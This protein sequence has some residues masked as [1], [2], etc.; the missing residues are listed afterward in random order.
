M[1][2]LKRIFFHPLY[3]K[4]EFLLKKYKK[5]DPNR[6]ILRFFITLAL[7]SSM[8]TILSITGQSSQ[9]ESS[10]FIHSTFLGG[11]NEDLI[12]DGE[13][14]Y[15]GNI[16]VTGQTLSPDFPVLNAFQDFFAGGDNDFHTIG[17]DAFI[18]K[19]NSEGQLLWSTY[20]GGSD[21]DSGQSIGL[22]T[23]NNIYIVGV[24]NSIDFPVTNGSTRSSFIGGDYD[25]FI[26]KIA[27]NGTMLYSSYFGT[28]GYDYTEDSEM[29]TSGNLVIVGTTSGTNLPI[30]SDAYQS[31][32][33]G[34]SDGFIA[35]IANDCS[36]IL[37][38]TYFGGSIGNAIG[39]IDIDSQDNILIDGINMRG[40]FPLTEDA[41]Q[42]TYDAT[43]RDFFIAKFN[44]SN[45]LVYSTFFG[46]SHM[47]DSFGVALDNS[48]NMYFSGRTW[49][50]DF[51][52]KNA[53]QKKIAND[54]PDGYIAAINEEN[55][56]LK[57]S[58][59]VGG[60]GWDTIHFIEVDSYDN[61]ITAGIGGPDGFPIKNAFQD[62]Y[63][64]ISDIVLVMLSSD[65]KP[66]FCSYIGGSGIDHPRKLIVANNYSLIVGQTNS[67]DFIISS[68]AYQKSINGDLD[69]FIFCFDYIS[70]IETKG[71]NTKPKSASGFTMWILG[72]GIT[73]L[74]VKKSSSKFN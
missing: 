42:S 21:R 10:E 11:S 23:L 47:D 5:W 35:R 64:G 51:P 8:F 66:F 69:G 32:R 12:R 52:L 1:K 57:F 40:D 48:G 24:T 7:I 56:Q 25:L 37:Y 15:E 74:L 46:G 43:Y 45:D 4:E 27:P 60:S 71:I 68:E 33:R 3:H 34:S 65:G 44:S 49:S 31:Y 73:L 9:P 19:F 13:L 61:I 16:I 59:Y 39:S 36:S 17:G 58:S 63:K 50:D 2:L 72:L 22:D 18:S 20:L 38:C 30:T 28:S 29:D 62:E 14:D 41:Y 55:G 54:T 67:S 70:Y 26:T 6:I 53:F